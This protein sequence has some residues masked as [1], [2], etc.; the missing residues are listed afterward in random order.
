MWAPGLKQQLTPTVVTQNHLLLFFSLMKQDWKWN[1]QEQK[2][3]W[4]RVR[5]KLSEW[6][7]GKEKK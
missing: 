4:E 7:S 6:E 2:S 1:R 3:F 5:V